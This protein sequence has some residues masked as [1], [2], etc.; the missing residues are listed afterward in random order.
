MCKFQYLDKTKGTSINSLIQKGS[1]SLGEL[2]GEIKELNET[3]QQFNQIYDDYYSAISQYSDL[4]AKYH[5]DEGNKN[6]GSYQLPGINNKLPSY[7]VES[8]KHDSDKIDQLKDIIKELDSQ[9][10][11]YFNMMARHSNQIFN[12]IRDLN[13][14]TQDL[15]VLIEDSNPLI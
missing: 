1:N 9:R 15:D 12:I 11:I 14:N 10:N 2:K 5:T 8:I 6:T 13:K 7:D 3:I 4:M